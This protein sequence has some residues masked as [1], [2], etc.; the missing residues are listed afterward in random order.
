MKTVE[1]LKQEQY[2]LKAR[3]HQMV[4]YMNSDGFFTLNNSERKMLTNQKIAMEMYLKC[5]S[6]RLYENLD[7]PFVCIPDFSWIG[8]AMG[9]TAPP[10]FNTNLKEEDFETNDDHEQ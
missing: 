9:L 1:E 8:I 2:D 4:E 7:N 3:L 10:S 5:L 6:I